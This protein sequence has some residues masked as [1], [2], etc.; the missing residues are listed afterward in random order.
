MIAY[1]CGA[2]VYKHTECR[3]SNS[4]GIEMCSDKD[5][6]GNYVIT[7]ATVNNAVELTKYLMNKYNID[8]NHIVRH[9]DVTGKNCPAPWVTDQSQWIAFKD[10]LVSP[11]TDTELINAVNKLYNKKI[12]K[13]VKYWSNIV[14]NK[15]VPSEWA[16]Q[17]ILGITQQNSIE[18]A[19]KLLASKS[20]ISDQNYWLKNTQKGKSVD[21]SFM[22]KVIIEGVKIFNI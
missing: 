2:K 12:I 13:D 17:V 22:K 3:N 8:K 9:F 6:K 14:S 19:V 1:H 5:S 18:Q 16:K 15:Q 7:P 10:K 20:V 21:S 11:S 4:I